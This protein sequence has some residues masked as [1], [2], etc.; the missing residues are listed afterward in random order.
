MLSGF[1]S[2]WES[3]LLGIVLAAVLMLP[4]VIAVTRSRQMDV[5]AFVFNA[6]R[7]SLAEITASVVCGNIGIGTFVA[8]FLFTQASPVIG[9]SIVVA[10]TIGLLLCAAL[11]RRIHD[12][13]ARA[14]A[15]GL[16]DLI[17]A[18]H[19][20]RHPLLVWLSVAVVFILRIMVQLAA[21]ALILAGAFGLSPIAALAAATVFSGCYVV[22]GGYKA[23]TETD[24]FH[25]TVILSL[26]LYVAATMPAGLDTEREFLDLGPY[27][28]VL[29]VGIFLFLPFSAVLGI[30]NWQRIA[31]AKSAE[32]ATKAYSI[33][34]IVCGL[35][36]AT[37]AAVALIPDAQADVLASFRALMPSGAPWLADVLFACAIVSTI[38]T[39]I[40]PLTTTFA[41]RGL[42]L[43]QL[44]LLVAALFALVAVLTGIMGDLLS[45]VIAAFNSLAVFLP[46][47]FGALLLRDPKP[48][49]AVASMIIGVTVSLLM[50]AVDVNSAAP[51]A[52][53]V[54]GTTYW[55]IHQALRRHRA[56][57]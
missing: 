21:L 55:L 48:E 22:I 14:G 6:G 43:G 30:D 16:V 44:R 5:S 50:M 1:Y 31:T 24:I 52:F 49:A 45:N 35:S 15:Y 25:A 17:V 10:Y 46:A 12:V 29:L 57:E 4:I 23:A 7:N 56:I 20:V 33:G 34:A 3:V 41:R 39:F 40:V 54:S 47:V 26:L 51:I 8:I 27:T 11:A 38:D 19:G 18:S 37:I 42:T 13:S 9:V 36:Y 32:V 2:G 28:P 53:A